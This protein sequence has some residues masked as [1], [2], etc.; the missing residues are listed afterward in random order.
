MKNQRIRFI[1]LLL[2]AAVLMVA[3]AGCSDDPFAPYEPEINNEAGTFQLQATGV[4]GVSL[5]RSYSWTSEAV[6]AN[7]NQATTVDRGTATLRIFDAA[8][9]MIYERSLAAN[10]TYA[11][12]AGSGSDWTIRIILTDYTGTVNFR[13]ES[14]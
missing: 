5:T 12:D 1:P 14:P 7:I 3:V 9:T 6:T 13:V 4:E 8:D 11:T 2:A 10:G